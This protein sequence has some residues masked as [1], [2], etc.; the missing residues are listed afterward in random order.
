M[1]T[2]REAS[3]G[4]AHA[5]PARIGH[6]AGHTAQ[7]SVAHRSSRALRMAGWVAALAAGLAGCATTDMKA[8][9]SET[10][11]AVRTAPASPPE[12]TL[13]NFSDAMR[14][15]DSLFITYGI[16]DVSVLVEDVD[17]KTK[18][19]AAGTKD[20]LI[21]AT[22]SMTRRSRAIRLVTFGQDSRSLDEWIRRSQSLSPFAELPLFAIRGSV[23][24]FDQNLAAK[25]GDAGIALSDRLSVGAA[26]R[27]SVS[28]LG[29][30]LNMV[31][32]ANFSIVPGVTSHNSILLY[33]EGQGI[34]GDAT[35]R[36]FGINF[37][38]T[39]T[40]TE[41]QAQGLRNLVDLAVIELYGR[42][43]RTPYWTCI[44]S[45][46]DSPEVTKE[47]EDWYY[48]MQAHGDLIPYVQHQLRGRGYYAGAL[49]GQPSPALAESVA[50]YRAAMGGEAGRGAIDFDFFKRYLSADHAQVLARNPAPANPPGSAAL[51][52]PPASGP[53]PSP[54]PT[55]APTPAPAPAPTPAPGGAVVT[56]PAARLRVSVMSATGD[57]VF[58]RGQPIQ[59]A[60]VVNRQA[61][62]HCF[63]RDDRQ[64]YQRIFP[65]RFQR[66]TL[67][68]AGEALQLPGQMRF[69]ILA[70]PRG[71]TEA[72][73]CYA[74]ERET[75]GR[76]PRRISG[77][78]FE[79]LPVTSFDEIK[80][81]FREATKD[82]FTEGVFLIRTR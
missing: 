44:G 18:K 13:T 29:I 6:R 46:A 67:L 22:S 56:E 32:G 81:A 39:I 16:R 52:P 68:R 78:D 79:N 4:S 1:K 15:M 48:A 21:S 66:D 3:M 20:M 23:S 9:V 50:L 75:I 80:D 10:A 12:R 51:Q 28:Q 62:L 74:T 14:C 49:D 70:S 59:L 60:V 8:E 73:I 63:L 33:S 34:D 7:A 58:L 30:D 57:Q 24:Q 76:L 11:R 27:A 69:Q 26:R 37:N 72:V 61:H 19:V 45:T 43:S 71:I 38:M 82:Q 41:G 47:L 77:G 64:Q 42:L 17:D 53:A 2:V 54:A 31:Y 40:K 5:R 65:N 25:E 55:P 35:I 36:K